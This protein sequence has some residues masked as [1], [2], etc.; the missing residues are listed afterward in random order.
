ML[1]RKAKKMSKL[2]KALEK[3]KETRELEGKTVT[4]KDYKNYQQT[5]GKASKNFDD[6][7]PELNIKYSKP[8]FKILDATPRLFAE[9]LSMRKMGGEKVG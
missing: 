6:C 1:L 9:A 8:T 7:R 4:G 3:A 5:N 2:K